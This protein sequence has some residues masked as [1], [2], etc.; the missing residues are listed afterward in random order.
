MWFNSAVASTPA[1]Q[2][3]GPGID[4]QRNHILGAF[5]GQPVAAD[6]LVTQQFPLEWGQQFIKLKKHFY[7]SYFDCERN[8]RKYEK[9]LK[10]FR[11]QE[12]NLNLEFLFLWHLV[13]QEL[14][15]YNFHY[16]Y[17]NKMKQSRKL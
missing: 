16:F 6:L 2:A 3:E 7:W 15:K 10:N 1:L 17:V 12:K 13:V 5:M 11:I 4:S 8:M 9:Y 14:L